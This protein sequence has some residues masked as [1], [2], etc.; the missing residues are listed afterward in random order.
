MD[1][2]QAPDPDP[3]PTVQELLASNPATA[4]LRFDDD[5]K[6]LRRSK[7]KDILP[8]SATELEEIRNT[9]VVF[10]DATS[11]LRQARQLT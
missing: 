5:G 3:V 4:K 11:M 7:D 1:P 10:E 9:L 8:L 2:K 6:L